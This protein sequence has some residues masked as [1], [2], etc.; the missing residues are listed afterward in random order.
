MKKLP[1]YRTVARTWAPVACLAFLC[2][3]SPAW[4]QDEDEN[5]DAT[6]IPDTTADVALKDVPAGVEQTMSR[7]LAGIEGPSCTVAFADMTAMVAF[8]Q[9]QARS[10]TPWRVARRWAADGA[11]IMS[12]S[13]GDYDH[14]LELNFSTN[15]PDYALFPCSL[16][17]TKAVDPAAYL[18]AYRACIAGR[19]PT[20]TCVAASYVAYEETTP[21]LQSGTSYAYTNLRSMVRA[22]VGGKSVLLSFSSMQG[23]SGF[24]IRGLPLGDP[25]WHLYYYSAKPG[26]NLRGLN[27][28]KP[29]MYVS[30]TLVVYQELSKNEMAVAVFSWLRAGWQ[31]INV[32]HSHHIYQV[33]VTVR[34][35]R[36]QIGCAAAVSAGSLGDIVNRVGAMKDEEVNAQYDLYCDCVKRENDKS[37]NALTSLVSPGSLRC[38]YDRKTL[39]ALDQPHRRALLVQERMRELLGTPTWSLT[40]FPPPVE[41]KTNSWKLW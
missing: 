7:V 8:V 24:A 9:V 40:N 3:A 36:N 13:T 35:T 16:R 19:V 1:G 2:F 4:A 30:K 39:D 28:V 11:G 23:M 15:A 20:N 12:V 27:W 21:N 38:L 32:T 22:N 10:N 5:G 18:T 41:Q 31:G 29:L 17:Y 26:T 37:G 25:Q 6:N 33:L 14:Q 34:D